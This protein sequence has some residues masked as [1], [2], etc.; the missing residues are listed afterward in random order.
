MGMK[1]KQNIFPFGLLLGMSDILGMH[2][3]GMRGMT[4]NRDKLDTIAWKHIDWRMS[5]EFFLL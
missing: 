5:E 1:T 3:K 2:L 4:S